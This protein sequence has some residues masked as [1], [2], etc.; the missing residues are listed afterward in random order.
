MGPSGC[1]LRSKRRLTRLKLPSTPAAVQS[2]RT[3][4][5]RLTNE[6]TMGMMVMRVRRKTRCPSDALQLCDGPR[7]LQS[8]PSLGAGA[9]IGTIEVLR[10]ALVSAGTTG[11]TT[12]NTKQASRVTVVERLT[13][14]EAEVGGGRWEVRWEVVLRSSSCCTTQPALQ[15]SPPLVLPS[16]YHCI[17]VTPAR[18]RR[19]SSESRLLRSGS[20]QLH[21]HVARCFPSNCTSQRLSALPSFGGWSRWRPNPLICS[22]HSASGYH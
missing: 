20:R 16:L 12:R 21:R 22:S 2:H 15:C 10:G 11:Q 13:A 8:N 6:Y 1:S 18:V 19:L 9:R 3:C 17:T 14:A 4:T 5:P 7:Q